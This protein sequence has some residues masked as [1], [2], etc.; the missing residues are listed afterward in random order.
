M[1]KVKKEPKDKLKD[2]HVNMRL[3]LVALTGKTPAQMNQKQTD[4]LLTVIGQ[5]LGLLDETG[6]VITPDA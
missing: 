1:A 3:I 4:D 5:M 6:A 2:K